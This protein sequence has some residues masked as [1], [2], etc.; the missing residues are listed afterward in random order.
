MSGGKMVIMSE[1]V[2]WNLNQY[3]CWMF[4]EIYPYFFAHVWADLLFKDV[5]GF[6]GLGGFEQLLCQDW[7]VI[8]WF[9]HGLM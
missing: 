1:Y 2:V 6:T 4:M 3:K 7:E 5:D 9:F 8:E